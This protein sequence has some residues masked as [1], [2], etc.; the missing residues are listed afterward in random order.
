MRQRNMMYTGPMIDT[1]IEYAPLQP[2]PCLMPYGP[3]PSGFTFIAT[4]HGTQVV[5]FG[6]HNQLV[7]PT[8]QVMERVHGAFKGKMAEG[9]HMNFQYSYSVHGSSPFVIPEYRG[10]DTIPMVIGAGH[11]RGARNR[12]GGAIDFNSG[13]QYMPM[14]Q[15]GQPLQVLPGPWLEQQFCGNAPGIPLMQGYTNGNPFTYMHPPPAP[16]PPMP[17]V[18]LQTGVELV[19]RFVRPSPPVG[20]RVHQPH[21]QELMIESTSRHRSFPHLRVLPED[22]VAMLEF[23]NYGHRVDHHRDMRLDI[24]HMSYEELLALGEQIGN[25]GSGLS[26]SFIACHLKTRTF[27]SSYPVD[28]SPSHQELNMCTICQM[29]Y[30]DKENIGKLD[31]SHEYHADCIQKWLV[32]KNTCPVCKCTGLGTQGK[33]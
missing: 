22:G 18:P 27:T 10:L 1:E 3:V 29:D 12:P 21:G 20:V 33:E 2:E 4:P 11:P 5:P 16:M 26:E 8:N 7:F 28:T 17:V 25:A 30:N 32:E 23:G 14:N 6:S 9:F 24:D 13:L 19:P 31:C 15:L